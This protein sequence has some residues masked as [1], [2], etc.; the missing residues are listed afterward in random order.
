MPRH[1]RASAPPESVTQ[2]SE[3]E[4]PAAKVR[5]RS[6]VTQDSQRKERRQAARDEPRERI[7]RREQEPRRDQRRFARDR[8]GEREVRREFVDEDGVRH[9][10]LPRG[11]KSRLMRDLRAQTAARQGPFLFLRGP[12]RLFNDDDED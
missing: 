11:E 2:D 1:E 8:A 4:K 5:E 3:A 12:R 6:R 7:V 10:I 9:I